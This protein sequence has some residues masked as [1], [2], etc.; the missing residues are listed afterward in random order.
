MIHYNFTLYI[1]VEDGLPLNFLEGREVN[2]WFIFLL[3]SPITSA[4]KS[5]NHNKVCTK[6]L[7]YFLGNVLCSYH[8][9]V[10]TSPFFFQRHSFF[11]FLEVFPFGRL[12]IEPNVGK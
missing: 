2:H 1:F 6:L 10:P 5:Y 9:L 4:I 3:N 7:F 12:K 8:E 11:M